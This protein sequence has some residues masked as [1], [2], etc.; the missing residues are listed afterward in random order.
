MN[1]P[2]KPRGQAENKTLA[3]SNLVKPGHDDLRLPTQ[4]EGALAEP[5]TPGRQTPAA[6]SAASAAE[7]AASAA[8]A[9]AASAAS[10]ASAAVAAATSGKLLTE[11]VCPG[12]FLVE[13]I[14][15]RQA[16]VRDF[17]VT[18]SDDLRRCRVRRRHFRYRSA[19]RC[20]CSGAHH[21][22][23]HPGDSQHGHSIAPTLAL[24]RALR[25]RHCRVPPLLFFEQML[26]ERSLSIAPFARV[27]QHASV[28]LAG[29][30][31]GAGDRLRHGRDWD[32]WMHAENLCGDIALLLALSF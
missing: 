17:F 5:A 29:I 18:E 31:L 21:R 8:S 30:G 9:A 16:D 27:E 3:G 28:G 10:A 23:R 7:A 1:L 26:K 24:R 13:D 14:E 32:R 11:L 15:C 22:Q 2:T 20:G 12:V 25:L 19:G 4:S 6:A